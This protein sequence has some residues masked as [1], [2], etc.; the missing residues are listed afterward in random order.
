MRFNK[1][2]YFVNDNKKLIEDINFLF[3]KDIDISSQNNVVETLSSCNSDFS[4]HF[5]KVIHHDN[6]LNEKYFKVI[7]NLIK[8]RLN[9][10]FEI[11]YIS[12]LNKYNL[13]NENLWNVIINCP[14]IDSYIF[15]N[16]SFYIK[17]IDKKT[18]SSSILELNKNHICD[19]WSPFFDINKGFYDNWYS[20][21]K[22]N[23][24][25]ILNIEYNQWKNNKDKKLFTS[26]IFK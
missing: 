24:L 23:E 13:S 26:L 7:Q 6:Q 20:K 15:L 4:K 1:N 12:Y 3:S 5:N 19:G 18:K 16:N 10:C 8:K 21:K 25:E 11:F 14:E 17:I 9:N 2:K 22:K